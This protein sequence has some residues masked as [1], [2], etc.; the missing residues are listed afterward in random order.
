MTSMTEVRAAMIVPKDFPELG[1]LAWNRDAT[2]PIARQ[3]AFELYDRNWRHVDAEHLTA[4]EAAL[5][6]ELTQEFGHG[7]RMFA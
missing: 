7:F 1:L 5:I 2:R 4:R 6:D 3:E